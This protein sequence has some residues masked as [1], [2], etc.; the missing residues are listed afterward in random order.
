MGREITQEVADKIRQKLCGSEK[1]K[2][3]SGHDVYPIRLD[4]LVVG[5]VSIRRS[6]KEVGHDYI[7][8]D[9]NVSMRFAKEIG[10]CHK[11]LDD[12]IECLRD[13]GL[14]AEKPQA[15]LPAPKPNF[16]WLEK[17]WVALQAAE[18]VTPEPESPE[19]D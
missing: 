1:P 18:E 17:D 15:T 6:S 16:P 5:R 7:P 2:T 19:G 3:T 9:I 14:I 13:K 12:Y 10:T 4:G 11:N 8:G